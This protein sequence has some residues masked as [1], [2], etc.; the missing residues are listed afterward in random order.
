MPR[1][2]NKELLILMLLFQIGSTTLYALGIE[3]KQ[4]SWIAILVALIIS[5]PFVLIIS[6]FQRNFP[7]KNYVEIINTIIGKWLGVPLS[8]LYGFL[9]FYAAARNVREFA[10]LTLF[11]FLPNTPIIIINILF[12]GTALFILLNG[13]EVLARMGELLLPVLIIFLLSVFVLTIVSGISDLRLLAPVLENGFQ[14]VLKAAYPVIV[15]FPYG[16][17]LVFSMYWQYISSKNNI[18][19]ISLISTIVSGLL[20]SLSSIVIVST[21]GPVVT[22]L[23]NVP[24]LEIIKLINIANILTN[25]DA[26][27]IVIMSIGGIFKMSLYINASALVFA[28]IFKIKNHKYILIILSI[29][30]VGYSI[31][32]E[33]SYIFHIWMVKQHAYFV[34]ISFLQIIPLLLFGIMWIKKKRGQ[35]E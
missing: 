4:D 8:L 5:I 26:I 23:I 30:L 21:L 27:A 17:I 1:I 20:L 2:S 18:R 28:S 19:N 7:N 35:I 33:P 16:E 25:F 15:F 9:W 29:I 22:S 6:E 24:L 11:T 14:P 13:F 32:Y 10:E 3:A 31:W 34:F 12:V